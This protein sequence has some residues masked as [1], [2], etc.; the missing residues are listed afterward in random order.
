MAIEVRTPCPI[1]LRW[2]VTVTTPSG[3]IETKM[4]GIVAPA[5]RH[6]VGA[7]LRFLVLRERGKAKRQDKGAGAHAHHD[8]AAADVFQS[9]PSA[10][11]PALRRRLMA[12]RMRG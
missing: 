1:S 4:R 3:V 8:G 12:A 11:R 5:V 2:T 7:E 10:C 6:A 9:R